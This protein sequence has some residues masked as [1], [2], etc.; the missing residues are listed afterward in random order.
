MSKKEYETLIIIKPTLTETNV[1]ELI[2]NI[3]SWIEGNEG[4]IFLEKNL[5][6]LE[7]KS[8]IKKETHGIYLQLHYSATNKTLNK[9]NQKIKVTENILR[10]LT[11]TLSSVQS[12]E[13]SVQSK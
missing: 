2:K 7:L 8:L 12:K 6:K 11:I 4:S 10:H 9:L 5:G 3:K 1:N 13:T